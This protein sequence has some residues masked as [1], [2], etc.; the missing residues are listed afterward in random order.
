[1]HLFQYVIISIV[2]DTSQGLVLVGAPYKQI[3]MYE[4]E[5]M[6]KFSVRRNV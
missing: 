4:I 1:M 6:L 2:T 3:K 5:D